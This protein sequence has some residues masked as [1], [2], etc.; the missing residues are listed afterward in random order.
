MNT[1]TEK[2]RR[3]RNREEG[4][5]EEEGGGVNVE[6]CRVHAGGQLALGQ[7]SGRT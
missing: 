7:C 3:W 4:G 6:R 5:G 2:E 1:S